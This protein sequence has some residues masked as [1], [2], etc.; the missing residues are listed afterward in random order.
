MKNFIYVIFGLILS[1]ASSQAL[2]W[3]QTTVDASGPTSYETTCLAVAASSGYA[4]LF[5]NTSL[6]V[7][8]NNNT[9]GWATSPTVAASTIYSGMDIGCDVDSNGYVHVSH[10]N[11]SNKYLYYSTNAPS[12]TWSTTTIDSSGFAGETALAVDAND[13]VHIAFYNSTS[14]DLYYINN[15]SGSWGSPTAVVTTGDVG[16]YLDI[17]TDSNS[18][19]HI[20]YYD[21]TNTE[22]KYVTNSSGSW[23]TPA[24]VDTT[25]TAGYGPAIAVDS[26]NKVHVSYLT[27]PS[28]SGSSYILRY[29]NN[30]SGNWSAETVDSAETHLGETSIAVASPTAVHISYYDDTNTDLKYATNISG[31]W[32]TSTVDGNNGGK[33]NSIAVSDSGDI[34]IGYV[35]QIHDNMELASN[36]CGNGTVDESEACDDGNETNSDGCNSICEIEPICGNG[37]KESGEACDDGNTSNTDD[38]LTTCV[39]ASCGD[40]N[41]W[42][43]GSGTETCDDG[44]R[45]SMDAC[46]NNCK[47]AVCGDSYIWNTGGGAETCD[48]SNTTDADGCS[49]TCL[50]EH[51]PVAD[52]GKDTTVTYGTGACGPTCTKFFVDGRL[53]T[54]PDLDAITFAWTLS[55]KPG[56]ATVTIVSPTSAKS[57]V[58]VSIKGAYTFTLTVTDADGGTAT[59]T[60]VFTVR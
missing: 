14:K 41:I 42:S 10:R 34:S 31:E 43:G 11:W 55:G 6:K 57:A 46:P 13:A 15:N 17:D 3:T 22:L 37:T 30:T 5:Y 53:S 44:N 1:L 50:L 47:T 51:P 52:A 60:V 54:D 48:D 2:A 33:Y 16:L 38:C 21:T 23:S 8:Y 26:D 7:Q 20:V 32:V 12:G 35:D 18:A 56:G 39:A 4:H 59:D 36:T 24:V 25:D 27:I 29:A 9:S 28:T 40:S 19:A 58:R 49:A 45:S